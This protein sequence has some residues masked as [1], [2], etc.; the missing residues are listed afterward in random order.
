MNSQVDNATG[1]RLALWLG[2]WVA[3]EISIADAANA[4]ETIT[5]S[6]DL[7]WHEQRMPWFNF[8]A[9]IPVNQT[10]VAAVFPSPG[11]P[12][13]VSPEVLR[14]FDISIGLV[15]L[16]PNILIG[17]KSDDTWLATSSPIT[18][19]PV[20]LNFARLQMLEA[21]ASAQSALANLDLTGTRAT[22]DAALESMNFGPMPPTTSKRVI[23]AVEQGFRIATLA[24]IAKD[25][26]IAVASRSQNAMKA[27]ILSDL[28]RCARELLQA[29]VSSG[30]GAI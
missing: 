15:A 23:D 28:E 16:W 25:D 29:A 13:G 27:E 17:K 21:L 6:L 18:K 20:D 5:H 4:C 10:S 1:C 19:I 24:R 12:D 30:Y 3:N 22:A 26:A 11:N 14:E 2:A 9:D 7:I 8:L